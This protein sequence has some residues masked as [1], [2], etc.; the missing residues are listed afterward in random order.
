[1]SGLLVSIICL[2]TVYAPL[3]LSRVIIVGWGLSAEFVFEL[4]FIWSFYILAIYL[5]LVIVRGRAKERGRP[6]GKPPK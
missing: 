5:I 6:N 2:L 1:M 4:A 3:E